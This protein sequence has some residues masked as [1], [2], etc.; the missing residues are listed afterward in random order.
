[1]YNYGKLR[2]EKRYRKRKLKEE[3]LASNRHRRRRIQLLK[4]HREQSNDKGTK[5]Y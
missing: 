5:L 4:N 1:M 3:S 2:E